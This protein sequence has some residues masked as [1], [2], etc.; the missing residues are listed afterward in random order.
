MIVGMDFSLKPQNF[1]LITQAKGIFFFFYKSQQN[2]IRTIRTYCINHI[3][4]TEREFVTSKTGG[5]PEFSI[6]FSLENQR[7]LFQT[8]FIIT[9]HKV[10]QTIS[11][12]LFIISLLFTHHLT[13]AF[14]AGSPYSLL[15]TTPYPTSHPLLLFSQ[16]LLYNG[17]F[18]F[19]SKCNSEK[20]SLAPFHKLSKLLLSLFDQ[21]VI[22]ELEKLQALPHFHLQTSKG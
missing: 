2:I 18:H 8:E 17:N 9:Y 7:R 5:N 13:V 20:R 12:T 15:S 11:S 4:R 16:I 21:E 19:H 10:Y 14:Y 6:F 1:Q 3:F 22:L